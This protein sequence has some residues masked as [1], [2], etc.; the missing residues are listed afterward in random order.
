MTINQR[1]KLPVVIPQTSNASSGRQ[2]FHLFLLHDL[3]SGYRCY[4]LNRVV[5]FQSD[6]AQGGISTKLP[7]IDKHAYE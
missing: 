4:Q 7:A 2:V 6:F 3:A 5:G 1:L